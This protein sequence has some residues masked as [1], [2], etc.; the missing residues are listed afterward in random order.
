MNNW[1]FGLGG[2]LV[3]PE[4]HGSKAPNDDPVVEFGRLNMWIGKTIKW[5]EATQFHL[6]GRL[7]MEGGVIDDIGFELMDAV[8]DL[9]G[10]QTIDLESQNETQGI[11]GAAIWTQT[12]LA[13][14]HM[15][16]A[17]CR[18]TPYGHASLGTDT[19][20]GGGGLKVEMLYNRG[21]ESLPLQLPINGSY[22]PAFGGDGIGLYAGGRGVVHET[23]YDGKQTPF[24]GEIGVVGQATLFRRLGMGVAI[25][26]TNKPYDGAVSSDCKSVFR[27]SYIWPVKKGINQSKL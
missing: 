24:I 27:V 2:Y 15:A 7:G 4:M 3:T 6:S 19:I 25:S 16:S 5:R 18:L 8:H 1:R 9:S 17:L 12:K 22:P 10:K 23:L 26:C 21:N 20:E 13:H 14:W 11:V